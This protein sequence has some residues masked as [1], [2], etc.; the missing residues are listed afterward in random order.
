MAPDSLLQLKYKL[1]GLFVQ[2]RVFC[3]FL[4]KVWQ[5]IDNRHEDSSIPEAIYVRAW[6][7]THMC[8]YVKY[9]A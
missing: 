7:H 8:T 6:K 2:L 3:N 5:M 4:G 9:D 1:K